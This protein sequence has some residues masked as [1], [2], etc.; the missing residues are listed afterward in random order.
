[1]PLGAR[2][3]LLH[4]ER[5]LGE[6]GDRADRA[7][8]P[9]GRRVQQVQ[10][11]VVHRRDGA[12]VRPRVERPV[13]AVERAT[14]GPGEL[15]DPLAV[16]AAPRVPVGHR[17]VLPAQAERVRHDLAQGLHVGPVLAHRVRP[18]RQLRGA[19]TLEQHR[20]GEPLDAVLRQPGRG[21]DLLDGL[22]R[23]DAGLDLTRTHLALQLDG[24]LAESGDVSPGG[25]AQPLVRGK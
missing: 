16:L 13:R 20:V 4:L 3:G 19:G 23:A 9:V 21:R 8:R 17:V 12:A 10:R 25:R 18:L 7:Q 2:L 5:L 6:L 1:V 14:G 24:D 15:D 11:V 22:S